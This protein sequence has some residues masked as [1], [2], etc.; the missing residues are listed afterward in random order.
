MRDTKFSQEELETIQRFYNSRRRTVCC[1]NPKLT[2]SEDVFFI[3]TEANQSNGIEAFA[4]YCE[5][6][7]QTK[8]F[9]LNV[10]HNAKF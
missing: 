8:I 2:F 1:S 6:C 3:P 5:N 10:M 7:G 4:T 9:N